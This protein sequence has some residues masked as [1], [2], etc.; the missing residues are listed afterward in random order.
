MR[1]ERARGR[2]ADCRRPG[3]ASR[4]GRRCRAT[5]RWRRTAR[6]THGQGTAACSRAGWCARP[7]RREPRRA[8]RPAWSRPAP[9]FSQSVEAVRV[10]QRVALLPGRR[11]A[12]PLAS[13]S[14]PSLR[15]PATTPTK[16]PSRTTATT[17]GSASRGLVERCQPRAGRGRPQHA[18]VQ[19]A[20]QRQV[21]DE[22]RPAEHLVGN[23][24]ALGRRAG[25]PPGRGRFR[26][27]VAG[28][29]AVEQARRRPAPSS[30]C[31]GCRCR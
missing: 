19:Q 25:Q 18:P 3:C 20:G 31:A 12:Q 29:L 28:R 13:P 15:P 5:A 26:R 11:C 9:L 1:Q 6:S 16:E 14:R 24:E 22:A 7:G 4:R 27:H 10:G 23:V 30:W 8:P 21:V 17:P 2:P